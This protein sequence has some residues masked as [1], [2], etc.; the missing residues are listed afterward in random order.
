MTPERRL[1]PAAVFAGVIDQLRGFVLPIIVFAVI[2]GGNPR[3][4]IARAALYTGIGLVIS[5]TLSAI[6]WS[7]TPANTAAG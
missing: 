2:G 6:S 5:T 1:H 3:E 7:I 4:S